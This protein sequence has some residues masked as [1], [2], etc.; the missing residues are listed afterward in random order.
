M[1]KCM[2]GLSHMVRSKRTQVFCLK[3]QRSV[4]EVFIL[5]S[6]K[7]PL[8]ISVS[9]EDSWERKGNT[10][11]GD[12]SFWG[13]YT[14]GGKDAVGGS[15]ESTTEVAASRLYLGHGLGNW[16]CPRSWQAVQQSA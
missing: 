16:E 12:R 9:S 15:E 11:H 5:C 3:R 4:R 6:K 1:T 8:W 10:F 2:K 14:D 13:K 7:K